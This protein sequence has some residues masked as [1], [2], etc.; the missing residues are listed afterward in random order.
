M[1]ACVGDES[2]AECLRTAGE[3]HRILPDRC[4]EC[5][6]ILDDK[7]SSKDYNNNVEYK[8]CEVKESREHILGRM[9]GFNTSSGLVHGTLPAGQPRDVPMADQSQAAQANAS[10][11]GVSTALRHFTMRLCE[12]IE[13]MKSTTY[14]EI[15][16]SLLADMQKEYESGLLDSAVEE[17]NLRRRVYDALNV[18]DAIGVVAKDKKNIE[19]LGWPTQ[20]SECHEI[21]MLKAE[22]KRLA[23][24]V[25]AKIKETYR[26][27]IKSFCLSNLILRNRDAPL[28]ALLSAQKSGLPSPTPLMV[29]F[30]MIQAPPDAKTDV[31]FADDMQEATINFR[32]SFFQVFDD[33]GVM[34]MM[35]LGEPRPDLM[36]SAAAAAGTHAEHKGQGEEDLQGMSSPMS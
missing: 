12:K 15:A 20:R 14:N 22:R 34:R 27:S 30:M 19:W 24:K 1:C 8:G 10:P 11:H 13:E 25:E 28:P 33:E 35:G 31:F 5:Q 36:E 32:N 7:T 21:R 18:L 4:K 17:K 29:P 6:A 2:V 16:D 23:L 9:A 26:T 3:A